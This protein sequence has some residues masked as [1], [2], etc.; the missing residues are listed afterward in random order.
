VQVE[1]FYLCVVSYL[2]ICVFI[3]YISETAFSACYV[4]VCVVSGQ[5][6]LLCS[7]LVNI[8]PEVGWKLAIQPNIQASRIETLHVIDYYTHKT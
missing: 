1:Y 3:D 4:H 5:L 6:S 7:L 8:E 2:Y